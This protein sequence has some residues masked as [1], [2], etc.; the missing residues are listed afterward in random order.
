MLTYSR[1]VD[2]VEAIRDHLRMWVSNS[3]FPSTPLFRSEEVI[4][5]STLWRPT[6]LTGS[7]VPRESSGSHSLKDF[8]KPGHAK[9]SVGAGF[10]PAKHWGAAHPAS[11]RAP[12]TLKS[13]RNSHDISAWRRL[14]YNGRVR[15]ADRQDNR[16]CDCPLGMLLGSPHST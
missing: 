4:H 1:R 13:R 5:L 12:G 3:P 14:A 15:P 7:I 6:D 2:C 16:V 10:P 8:G 11:S 9:K